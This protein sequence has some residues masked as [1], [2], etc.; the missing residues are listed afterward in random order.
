MRPG[1]DFECGC[2]LVEPGDK[3]SPA[4]GGTQRARHG[5]P[6]VLSG[7][8]RR[9]FGH[10]VEP[11]THPR[12]TRGRRRRRPIPVVATGLHHLLALVLVHAHARSRQGWHASARYA[13][14]LVAVMRMQSRDDIVRRV[15]LQWQPS[16]E[17][18]RDARRVRADVYRVP[19]QRT[20]RCTQSAPLCAVPRRCGPTML[21][22]AMPTMPP[23]R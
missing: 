16:S 21:R 10:W 5:A 23:S 19:R 9:N 8:C 4:A 3:R 17:H 11:G 7:L 22:S 18:S 13:R 1:G 6:C 15:A 12:S 20:R 2:S 14:V